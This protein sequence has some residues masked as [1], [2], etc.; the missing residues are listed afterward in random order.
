M[1]AMKQADL[2]VFLHTL[3]QGSGGQPDQKAALSTGS[4]NSL[5]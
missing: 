5:L 1:E 4:Q 3:A 2:L